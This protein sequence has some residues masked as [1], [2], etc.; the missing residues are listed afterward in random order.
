MTFRDRTFCVNNECKHRLTCER[1]LTEHLRT[2]AGQYE[3]L[4]SVSKWEP[5][6]CPEQPPL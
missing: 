3:M 2:L 1:Y 6:D 4:I 5:E